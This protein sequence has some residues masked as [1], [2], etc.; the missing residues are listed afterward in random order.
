MAKKQRNQ[1]ST[2]KRK[3]S[4]SKD[5]RDALRSARKRRQQLRNLALGAIGILVVGFFAFLLARSAL[6]QPGESVA[7]QGNAHITPDQSDSTSYNTRPPTSG[8]HFGQLASW[9]VHDTPISDGAQI[10]NLEDGGVGIWYN[11][12]D[13]CPDLVEQLEGVMNDLGKDELLLAPYPDMDT[14]IALTAWNRIDKFE[15]FDQ[16]RIVD[17]IKAYRGIDHHQG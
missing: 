16:E 3:S 10:H 1:K 17:F 11:C 7:S 4:T 6:N 15:D 12:P 2:A 13:G 8:P 9:G 14:R 5:Q